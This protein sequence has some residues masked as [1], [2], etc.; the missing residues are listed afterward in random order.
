MAKA[1]EIIGLD[2]EAEAARGMRLV[3][4]GRLEEMCELRAAALDWSSDDGVHDMRVASR[5]LRSALRD[6]KLHLRA[7]RRLDAARAELKRL[8][9]ALGAVRDEDVAIRALEKLKEEAGEQTASE[10]FELFADARRTRRERARE[11]LTRALDEESFE[12]ARRQIA[13]AFE[14]ATAPR[15]RKGDAEG[16]GDDGH[17][18]DARSFSGLGRFIIERSWDELREREPSLYRPLKSGP[19]HKMRIAAKR[20]RYALELFAACFG[21]RSKELAHELAELQTALGELHDCDEWVKVFGKHLS[22]QPAAGDESWAERR[23]AALWMLEHFVGQRSKHYG[24]ALAIW[25]GMEREGFAS[26]LAICLDE[27]GRES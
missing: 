24:E 3:L 2:C 21:E 25:R 5:R 7:T 18:D 4:L 14:K 26:Q 11:E 1:K 19:L 9:D 6:F 20:L 10:G 12:S 13:S 16:D 8:A 17:G 27:A 15:K 22:E 23:E